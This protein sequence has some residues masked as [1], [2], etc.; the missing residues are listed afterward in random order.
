MNSTKDNKAE[1]EAP[2]N[3]SLRGF[4]S[5][6]RVKAKL[7]KACPN[8]VS[9]ADVLTLMARDA[10]WLVRHFLNKFGKIILHPWTNLMKYNCLGSNCC[11]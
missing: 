2:P 4:G 7:E 3:C 6:E 10:V 11:L 9:C 8:T 1:N 5:V